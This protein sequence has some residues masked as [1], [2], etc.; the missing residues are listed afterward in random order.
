[1]AASKREMLGFLHQLR[2]CLSIG[3]CSV[4]AVGGCYGRGHF[5]YEDQCILSCCILAYV[6]LHSCDVQLTV[7]AQ[8]AE[9][10]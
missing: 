1:M 2:A 3:R 9:S 5:V 8:V 4:W 7:H 10:P 6:C